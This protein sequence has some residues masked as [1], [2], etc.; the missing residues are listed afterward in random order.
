MKKILIGYVTENLG[1]GVNQYIVNFAKKISSEDIQID[2]LTREDKRSDKKI[3]NDILSDVKYNNLYYIPKNKHFISCIKELKSIIK[4]ENY[5]IAYFN[6]S[7]AYD[8]LGLIAAKLCKVKKIISHSHSS[9]VA[10]S[11]IINRLIKRIANFF[12]KCIVTNCSNTYLACSKKAAKWLYTSHV[13]NSNDYIIANN[14][15]DSKNFKFNKNKRE[16]IRKELGLNDEILIGH[17]ARFDLSSKNNTFAVDILEE[18]LKQNNNV[19]L[20]CIGGGDDFEKVKSYAKKKNLTNHIIYTGR[21]NNVEDYIHAMDI[22]ILPSKFEGFPITG[23]EAQFAGLPCLFSNRITNEIIIGKNSKMLPINSAKAWANEIIEKSKERSNELLKKAKE[24]DLNNNNQSIDIINSSVVEHPQKFN[25]ELLFSFLFMLEGFLQAFNCTVGTKIISFVLWPMTFL[26][27]LILLYRL[28][29]LKKY[30][31]DFKSILLILF[32]LT[33]L[34]PT[35]IFR[36]YRLYLNIKFFILMMF[37]FGILYLYS[38]KPSETKRFNAKKLAD[39]FIIFALFLVL[40]SLYV[41]VINY[42]KVINTAMDPIVYGISANRLFGVFWDPNIGALISTMAF[43]MAL[44]KFV[45]SN[46]KFIKV[47]N[48]IACFLFA[49]YI[50]LS[51]SRMGI[52]S[53]IVCGIFYILLLCLSKNKTS[54]KVKIVLIVTLL[55]SVLISFQGRYSYNKVVDFVNKEVKTSVKKTNNHSKSNMKTYSKME[56]S[57]KPNNDISNRRMDIWKSG[58]EIAKKN[59]IFGIGHANVL[60]YVKDELPDSYIINNSQKIFSSMHNMLMDTL[61]SQGIIGLLLYLAFIVIVM[62]LV[63]KNLKYLINLNVDC[64][65]LLAIILIEVI[66]SLFITEI[67]YIDSPMSVIFWISLGQLVNYIDFRKEKRV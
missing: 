20:I 54:K 62:F 19:K 22:F 23:I 53:L 36:K 38:N 47:L 51:A 9:S 24:Y 65:L 15:I 37:Q 52:L 7:S 49:F 32:D 35:I 48:I 50:S 28:I 6:I 31:L 30:K 26:G 8:C 21:I 61:V 39:L 56:R 14:L 60:P 27:G 64:I 12:G 58:F 55:L 40:G 10:E 2:F 34:V 59:P 57:F 66:A 11:N 4:K 13:Y 33:L 3:K 45:I 18:T 5:D 29:N 42:N 44:H 25:F 17:I 63:L 41:L 1:A 43:I 16:E 46:S 67:I